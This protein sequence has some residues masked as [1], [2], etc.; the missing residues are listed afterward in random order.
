MKKVPRKHGFTLIELVLVASIVVII[1]LAVYGTFANG[2]NIWKRITQESDVEDV[3]LFFEKISYDLHNSF[4]M[5]GMRF[6]GGKREASF[7]VRIKEKG[8]NGIQ[9]SIGEVT[10]SLDRKRKALIRQE[11][12][13]SE[14]YHKKKGPAR[15][16]VNN[17]RSLEFRYFTYDSNEKK[18]KWSSHWQQRDDPFGIKKEEALP[19]IVKIEVGIQEG[20]DINK[21]VK[22]VD[23]PSACCWPFTEED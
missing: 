21:F 8:K 6:R 13:Y 5:T 3:S 20:K 17:I 2:I 4:K 23:V 22:T 7:P 10:Y 1:G 16:L 12:N 15:V 19:L 14:A 11:V 18:Y 9:G